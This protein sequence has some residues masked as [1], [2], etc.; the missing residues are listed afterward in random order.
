VLAS[1]LSP[2]F[3]HRRHLVRRLWLAS[4]NHYYSLLW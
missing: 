1:I 4:R 3:K 2:N